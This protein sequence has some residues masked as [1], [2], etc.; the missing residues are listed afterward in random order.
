M[1]FKT[2]LIT[3]ASSGL[4]EALSRLLASKGIALIITGRNQLKLEE[5]AKELRPLIN[6]LAL[7]C[8]LCKQDE[9]KRLLELLNEKKPD[10]VINNAGFGIYSKAVD[11]PI[12]DQLDIYKVNGEVPLEITLRSISMFKEQKKEGTVL[13]V[14]SAAIFQPCPYLSTYAAAKAFLSLLS[15]SLDQEMEKE[16]IRVLTACPGQI[17]TRFQARASGQ[18][19]SSSEKGDALSMRPEFVAKK[20]WNQIQK[21]K[22]ITVIDW[23]YRLMHYLGVYL[24]TRKFMGKIVSKNILKRIIN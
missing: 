15:E 19:H 20:I 3:G 16:G 22:T 8:D 10:L 5:L 17:L 1:H 14:C 4:G 23:R 21:G 7:T 18:N 13:N 6:V 11:S 24:F 2:A 9:L 12:Q